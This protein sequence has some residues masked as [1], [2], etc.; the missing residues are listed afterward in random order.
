MRLGGSKPQPE[1]GR[2]TVPEDGEENGSQKDGV[3][4]EQT[5]AVPRKPSEMRVSRET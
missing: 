2:V 1:A 4:S 3:G 5:D